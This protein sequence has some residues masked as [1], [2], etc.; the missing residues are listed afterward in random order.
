MQLFSLFWP[1][2]ILTTIVDETNCN[3]DENSREG[4]TRGSNMWEHFTIA[5]LKA[6]MAIHLYRI[7]EATKFENILD[8]KL[9]ISL[10]YYFKYF[11]TQVI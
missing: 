7:E 5:S 6:F 3:A 9:Y 8:A 10:S 11:H 4:G 1:W 2:T